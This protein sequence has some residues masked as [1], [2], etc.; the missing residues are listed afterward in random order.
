MSGNA[1][2]LAFPRGLL[3]VPA[4]QPARRVSVQA[5][6]NRAPAPELRI[7]KSPRTLRLRAESNLW[8][9]GGDN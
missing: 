1:G 8:E 3:A 7:K 2:M 6:R 4:K 9:D 5:L